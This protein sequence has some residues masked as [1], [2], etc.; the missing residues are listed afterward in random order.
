MKKGE[1]T[2][3][4]SADVVEVM[5]HRADDDNEH[6]AEKRYQEAYGPMDPKK[7]VNTWQLRERIAE[8]AEATS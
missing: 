7:R 6:I 5:T 8:V 4:M 3:P 2:N 1:K